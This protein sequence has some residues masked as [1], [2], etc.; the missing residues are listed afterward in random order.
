MMENKLLKCQI[1][2]K[3]ELEISIK[4][5]ERIFFKVILG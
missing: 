2:K 1:L 3:I 4:Q 5:I